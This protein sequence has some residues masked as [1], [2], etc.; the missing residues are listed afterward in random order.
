MGVM[1]QQEGD[2]R[3]CLCRISMGQGK[4][5]EDKGECRPF[6]CVLVALLCFGIG[7]GQLALITRLHTK[8]NL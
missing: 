4:V 6:L 1:H 3:L 7:L 5:N 2:R 8:P